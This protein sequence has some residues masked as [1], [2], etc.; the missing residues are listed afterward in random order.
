MPSIHELIPSKYL[1]KYQLGDQQAALYTISNLR[2]ENVGTEDE[3]VE[4]VVI[5]FDETPKGFVANK[6]NLNTLI[7]IYGE[8]YEGWVG[9]KIVVY[10]DPTIQ[11]GGKLVGGLR[12]RAP[13][14]AVPEPD[15]PF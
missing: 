12:L 6:T 14:G 4:K 3:E 13:K 15:L 10:F 1:T 5:F 11:Y 8:D 9:K 2:T 7:A